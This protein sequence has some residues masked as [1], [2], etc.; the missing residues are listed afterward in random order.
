M[1][2]RYVKYL[3]L[4]SLLECL[5]DECME[6]DTEPVRALLVRM[7]MEGFDLFYSAQGEA[8]DDF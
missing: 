2:S 4:L 6:F 3:Y 1:D 5:L 8:I 7:R